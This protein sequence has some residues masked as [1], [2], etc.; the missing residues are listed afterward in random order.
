M[1]EFE[2]ERRAYNAK[3]KEFNKKEMNELEAI[4]RK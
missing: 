2:A 3:K 1:N 4:L